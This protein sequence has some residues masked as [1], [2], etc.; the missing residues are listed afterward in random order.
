VASVS[1]GAAREAQGPE[2]CPYGS[3]GVVETPSAS[4]VRWKNFLTVALVFAAI[5][6]AQD[7]VWR[8][9]REPWAAFG[10]IWQHFG[11]GWS[12]ALVPSL[13]G[14]AGLLSF[15]KPKGPVEPI[16][17]LVCWRF[18]SRGE[19]AAVLAE[20]IASVHREMAALPLFPHVIEVV[21][22]VPVTEL[23]GTH[24]RLVHIVVPPEYETSRGARYKARA[25]QYALEQSAIPDD[26]WIVHLDEESHCTR[27]LVQGVAQAVREEE[28]SGRLRIG[29]G[30]ILY[31][32]GRR[33]N[34]ILT[35]ADSI[36]TGDDYARFALSTRLGLALFGFH[37][38]FILVRN[39]VAKRVGFDFGPE[40]SITEDAFWVLRQMELG[41]RCRFVDG[42]VVEQAPHSVRDF[43]QQRRRWFVGLSLVVRHAPVRLRFK[44]PLALMT[45]LWSVSWLVNLYTVGNLIFGYYEPLWLRAPANL[46]FAYFLS[47][48]LIG[49]RMHLADR[50]AGRWRSSLM[51]LG[52]VLLLPFFAVL[53]AGSVLWGL[54][55]PTAGFHVIQKTRPTAMHRPGI[56]RPLWARAFAPH[57][58][59]ETAAQEGAAGTAVVSTSQPAAEA[60]R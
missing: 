24:A 19:N 26:A 54:V 11:V 55:K 10:Q 57:R 35:L 32:R 8:G 45:G 22:D 20:S 44:A 43:M 60:L 4:S 27:S 59:R 39:D 23:T 52:Q 30:V 38:S 58:H 37:G 2:S 41:T 15:S 51:F 7:A 13:F 5:F 21:T 3:S 42:Y 33:E 46:V 14:L 47:L 40:G 6:A 49:L 28:V 48:Y 25:L 1:A 50:P 29:Q 53:E 34:P 31:H 36:R 16:D 18:V 17:A 12:L 9:S 56:L